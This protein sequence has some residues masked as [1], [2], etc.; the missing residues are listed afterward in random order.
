MRELPVIFDEIKKNKT[1]NVDFI[2]EM[3]KKL[4]DGNKTESEVYSICNDV[5]VYSERVM[6][7]LSQQKRI[8]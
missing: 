5:L 6:V 8:L 4:E 7:P 2:V 3:K 1:L